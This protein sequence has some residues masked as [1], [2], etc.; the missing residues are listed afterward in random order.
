METPKRTLAK[1]VTWQVTG[2]IS[3]AAIGYV[4]TGDVAVAGGLAI[5]STVLGTLSYILHERIWARVAWGRV[6]LDSVTKAGRTS[7]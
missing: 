6:R 1:A 5:T 4:A 3:M 7:S 2:L